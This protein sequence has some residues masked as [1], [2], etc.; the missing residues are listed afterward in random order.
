MAWHFQLFKP[1]SDSVELHFN[2]NSFFAE[3]L[4][5]G[6][7]SFLLWIFVGDK[8]LFM[9]KENVFPTEWACGQENRP[10]NN[11]HLYFGLLLWQKEGKITFKRH[12]FFFFFFYFPAKKMWVSARLWFSLARVHLCYQKKPSRKEIR[13]CGGCCVW[14]TSDI[15]GRRK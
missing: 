7:G 12:S 4:K 11:A 9:L 3:F 1:L 10:S 6:L 13:M 14:G 5:N 8:G 15:T 2:G